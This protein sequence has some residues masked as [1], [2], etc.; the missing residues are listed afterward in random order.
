MEPTAEF[1]T[2]PEFW[3]STQKTV[4]IPLV[5]Y[6]AKLAQEGRKLTLAGLVVFAVWTGIG[7]VLCFGYTP[8]PARLVPLSIVGLGAVGFAIQTQ[9]MMRLRKNGGYYRISLDDYGLYVHS[10]DPSLA[11]AFSVI[12][13]EVY[14]LVRITIKQYEGSDE[15]EYY[16]ET[17]SGSRHRIE[18]IFA[19]YD[20]DVMA[21]FERIAERFPWVQL[22]EE[23][24]H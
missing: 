24:K 14:R 21:M 10:D 3:R 16:V 4:S 8:F 13:P 18:Q 11:P 12:A 1:A 22:V 17:K 5:L 23:V 20:L 2:A 15:L 7:G 9:R 6:E 19:D